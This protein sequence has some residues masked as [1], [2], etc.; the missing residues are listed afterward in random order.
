MPERIGE[1]RVIRLLGSGSFGAVYEVEDPGNSRFALKTV[2]AESEGARQGIQ[3]EFNNRNKINDFTHVAKGYQ[4]LQVTLPEGPGIAYPMELLADNLGTVIERLQEASPEEREW[5]V[6]R[7]WFPQILRGV[8]ACHEVDFLHLDLKPSNILVSSDGETLKIT[9]F[10]ISSP[11]TP[12][13]RRQGTP[14]YMAPEQVAGGEARPQTDIYALGVLLTEMLTGDP[15]DGELSRFSKEVRQV[16]ALATKR[17]PQER[18]DSIMAMQRAWKV[19]F[20]DRRDNRKDQSAGARN[21]ASA[22]AGA[23]TEAGAEAQAGAGAGAATADTPAEKETYPL[24]E[25]SLFDGVRRLLLVSQTELILQSYRRSESP[26][27][28]REL[29]EERKNIRSLSVKRGIRWIHVLVFYLFGLPFVLT[30]LGAL[31]GR[32]IFGPELGVDLGAYTGLAITSAA[33]YGAVFIPAILSLRM[34]RKKDLVPGGWK[35]ITYAVLHLE[36]H[37]GKRWELPF[38]KSDAYELYR[39]LS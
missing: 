7:R 23:K 34:S 32:Y 27:R 6:T 25:G 3:R 10:G 33:A 39:I 28:P 31:F 29:K 35:G 20:P 19:L 17:S 5:E 36:F 12:Q 1:Y 38:R 4:P 9:D 14:A 30:L 37:S 21:D 2:S 26:T 15:L 16:V 13:A 22:G 18:F 11:P 8:A 24:Q